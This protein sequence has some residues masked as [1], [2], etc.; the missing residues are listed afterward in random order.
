[1]K[2]MGTR[3]ESFRRKLFLQPARHITPKSQLSLMGIAMTEWDGV[4]LE[5]ALIAIQAAG[6]M[7]KRLEKN[8][9]IMGDLK[10][11]IYDDQ[12]EEVLDVVK[13]DAK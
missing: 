3:I 13:F 5:E 12:L 11:V 8:V 6:V 9:A 10:T 7:A 4:D 1:L 2:I